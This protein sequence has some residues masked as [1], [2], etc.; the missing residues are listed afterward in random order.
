MRHTNQA[1]RHRQRGQ[2]LIE[3]AVTM[4]VIFAVVFWI[5]ELGAL[6]YTRSVIAD[7][8]NEGVRYATVHSGDTTTATKAIVK[9]FTNT[10][11]DNGTVSTSVAYPNGTAPPNPVQVTV[12]YSYVPWLST[13]IKALNIQAYA[14][15]RMVVQ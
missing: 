11:L 6:M 5:I 8:A 3:T 12:T 15:G 2:A 7:A 9:A 10:S 4:I 14:E 1:R 13:Y